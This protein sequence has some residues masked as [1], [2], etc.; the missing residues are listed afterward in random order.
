[1]LMNDQATYLA[2]GLCIFNT[3]ATLFF[4]CLIDMGVIHYPRRS[5]SSTAQSHFRGLHFILLS[6]S[7]LSITLTST[8]CSSKVTLRPKQLLVVYHADEWSGFL[9]SSWSLYIQ[10]CSNFVL[11]L[12][13]WYG[14]HPL[15]KEINFFHRSI[16]LQGISFHTVVC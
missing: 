15:S 2:V 13:D 11:Y 12:F 7:C 16:V 4:I 14:C 8:M 5:M 3:A 6:A 9:L 10:Y 1:M